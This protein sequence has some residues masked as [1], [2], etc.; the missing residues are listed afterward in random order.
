VVLNFATIGRCRVPP[1]PRPIG[2]GI[3]W[4][5]G[6]RGTHWGLCYSDLVPTS[7][8][9]LRYQYRECFATFLKV[10]VTDS[11]KFSP[12]QMPLSPPP[13]SSPTHTYQ[14]RISLL[15]L[16]NLDNCHRHNNSKN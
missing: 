2:T 15:L 14:K 10:L 16:M 6:A 8:Y 4:V 11:E 13:P 7:K 5:M 1:L 3:L 12:F 9:S